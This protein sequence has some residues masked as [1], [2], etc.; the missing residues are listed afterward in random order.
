VQGAAL[1]GGYFRVEIVQGRHLMRTSNSLKRLPIR[2]CGYDSTHGR[3]S[4]FHQTVS[5]VG[6]GADVN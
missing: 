6:V 4:Q 1:A 5:G 3:A 2:S